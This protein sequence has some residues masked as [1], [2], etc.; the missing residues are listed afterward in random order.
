MCEDLGELMKLYSLTKEFKLTHREYGS[1]WWYKNSEQHLYL[2][3]NLISEQNCLKLAWRLEYS[4]YTMVW[5]KYSVNTA[6]KP[7]F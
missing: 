6:N 3:I 4:L 5:A 2:Y 1:I 7:S